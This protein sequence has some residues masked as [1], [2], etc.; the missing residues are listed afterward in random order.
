MVGHDATV[1]ATL[2]SVGS[3]PDGLS[4][5]EAARR[6]LAHGENDLI[7]TEGRRPLSILVAQFS[8]LL[9]GVLVVAALLSAAVGHAIDALLIG[10]IVAANGAF[11]FV[12]DYRAEQSLLA[13]RKLATPNATVRRDGRERNIP[14]TDVVPG[15]MLILTQGSAVMADARLSSVQSLEC[16]EAPLTGESLPVGKSVAPVSPDTPLAERTNMVYRGTTVTR[17]RGEAVVVATGMDTEMGEIAGA[18]AAATAPLTPLQRDLAALGKSLGIGILFVSALLAPILVVLAGTDAV[19]AALAAVSLAVAAIPEGLPAVVTLTLA[20]GVR[21]MAAEHALV[22]ALPA[23]EALG[24]VDIIC[25]DKTGTVT[26]GE[27]VVSQVWVPDRVY[28]LADDPSED[29]RLR[30]L[31]EIGVVCNDATDDVGD[32]TE[33]ALLG[34]ARWYGLDPDAVRDAHPRVSERPFSAETQQMMTVHDDVAFVKGAPRPVLDHCSHVH[35]EAGVVPLTDDL[36][37]QIREQTDAFAAAALRV[38]GFA[39]NT[40]N[41]P[42]ESLIF[43]GLQGLLDPPRPEV[44]TAIAECHRA[45]IDVKLITGDNRVTASVIAA[46]IGLSGAT[47]DGTELDAMDDDELTA[48]LSGT[49]VFARATPAHKVRILEALQ[50]QGHVVAMTG[51]G[52]NDAPALKRADVGVAMGIRGTDVAAQSSDIVL[53][54]DNF[55]TIRTAIRNGRAVFDNIWKFV[56]YLLSA[57]FAEVLLVFIASL[58]G[59]LILPA[60]QLLWINLLTDGL[61]ALALGVDSTGDDV[62]DRQPRARATGILDRELL[63]FVGG[64]GVAAALVMLGLMV[65]VLDGAPTVTPYALTMVFTG[66]VLLEFVKLFVVRWLR[67]TPVINWWLFLAVAGSLALQLAVVY[68]PLRTYFGTVPLSLGDWG[69]LGIGMVTG[70]LLFVLVARIVRQFVVHS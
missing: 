36:R 6:L 52:V 20:L 31:F 45:G 38:L 28:S 19:Q 51:D 32:P 59:Y 41:D 16:D 21:R 14:A 63:G 23:V 65:V 5:D 27:M 33:Q 70:G 3:Q 44:A 1:E 17:G 47:L 11:G 29:D 46:H 48:R 12:Q 25:T 69:L 61:P 43:V 15:D 64:A 18:L 55:A 4:S 60:V 49:T 57:N 22:R 37:A 10:I 9:I 50:A 30:R 39:Y 66:F 62:M 34:S 56:A 8:S 26:E 13:L 68:T 7:D 24:T 35:T 58:A 2:D 42:D 67:G 40:T 54:D 53:L